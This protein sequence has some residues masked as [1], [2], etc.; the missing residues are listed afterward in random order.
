MLIENLGFIISMPIRNTYENY[1]ESYFRDIMENGITIYSS[2]TTGDPKPIFQPPKK[3]KANSEAAIRVQKITSDS[4]IYT[5]LRLS[6]AG[7]LFA[8]TIPGLEAGATVDVEKFNAYEYVKKA[9]NYTH[10]H[11]TPLQAKAVMSTKNFKNLDLSGKT[12]MC[13]AEPVTY[14][15]IEAFVRQGARFICIWGMSEVGPNAIM[16]VF[17]D[18]AEV[19]AMKKITPPNSTLIGNIFNCY[20]KIM[21][22]N[23][24][25]V[26]GD[27]CVYDDWFNT[28][29]QMIYKDGHLF[30]TG[31][32]G[33]AV[34]LNKP[35]KG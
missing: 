11:L 13:G 2:G 16:H 14:D 34:D 10:T 7:G 6:H 5:C 33:V 21:D 22:Q 29:D 17:N 26:M 31:R 9:E 1:D 3:I 23:Q 18:M 8:Q 15:I 25:Y 30:Y 4:V 28:K 27:I 24:L 35:R 20:F 19:K 12:F 32:E